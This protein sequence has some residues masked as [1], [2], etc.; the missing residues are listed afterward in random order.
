MPL[1]DLTVDTNVFLH[2]CNPIETRFGDAVHF[3][4]LLVASTTTLAIDD[5]FNVDPAK[6]T[7]LIGGEYLQKFV[8]GSLAHAVVTTLALN[9]RIAITPTK[10]S[11]GVNKKLN[12]MVANRRDRTFVKVCANSQGKALVTHDFQDFSNKK[13]RDLGVIFSIAIMEACDATALL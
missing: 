4:S 13:R 5:G 3:L 2:S 6:N 8:P 7:S 9:A 12:Q 10:L 11:A 1:L